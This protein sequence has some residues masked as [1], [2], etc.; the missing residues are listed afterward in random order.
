[1]NKFRVLFVTP[2]FQSFVKND[3]DILQGHFKVTINHYPWQ[4]KGL[5]PYYFF[6]QF[7]SVL[8]NILFVRFIIV[9]F[10][11]YWSFWPSVLGKLFFKKVF[12]ILHGTDCASLPEIKY[13]SLRISLLKFF[14]GISYRCAN[15]LLPVSESLAK[16]KL[17]F[18]PELENKRQG[19]QYHFPGLNTPFETIYNGF[20]PAFWPWGEWEKRTP[21]SFLAVFSKE[22]YLLKGGDLIKEVA[23]VFPDFTFYIA[24][25]S[26]AEDM[27]N[28]PQNLKFLGKLKQEELSKWYQKTTYYFQLSIFEG[29]G[30]ALCEAMLSGCIPIGSNVNHIPQII[31]GYGDILKEKNK[32]A[33]VELI[34]KL[35]LKNNL[36]DLS[37]GAR[38][39]II[40]NYSLKLRREKLLG[41]LSK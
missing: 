2:S 34:K 12:I 20:D 37:K 24:G 14:C 32:E 5:A 33:L 27:E 28:I 13:G 9:S 40:K 8:K 26:A 3:I 18:L 39:H 29:F 36:M 7:F 35:N 4:N 23:P 17:T 11:G 41:V 6:L 31:S 10:G 16:T 22:Q 30:C 19:F 38:G 25:M 15:C 1:M 21:N